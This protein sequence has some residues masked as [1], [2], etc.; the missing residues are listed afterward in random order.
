MH[1][2]LSHWTLRTKHKFKDK[3]IKT[4]K[5]AQQSGNLGSLCK[6]IECKRGEGSHHSRAKKLNGP[7]EDCGQIPQQQAGCR[8]LPVKMRQVQCPN[9]QPSGLHNC[10]K[11]IF[12]FGVQNPRSSELHEERLR[13]YKTPNRG[14]VV[15][16]LWE[17][18]LF[19]R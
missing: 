5:M 9:A 17:L 1:V 14:T 13:A 4:F 10:L 7:W 15:C 19:L 2:P 6:C 3:L 11:P 8:D 18:T 16:L 12:T